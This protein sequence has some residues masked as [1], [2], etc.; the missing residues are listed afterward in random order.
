MN[1]VPLNHPAVVPARWRGRELLIVR[2]VWLVVAITVV[3]AYFLTLYLRWQQWTHPTATNLT[4]LTRLG[5]SP[6]GYAA[7]FAW[8]ELVSVTVFVITG[9]VLFKQRGAER[10]ALLTGLLLII[11]GISIHAYDMLPAGAG[12]DPAL[13]FLL[14]FFL[15]STHTGLA[16]F[17]YL[18]PNGHFAPRWARWLMALHSLFYLFWSFAPDALFI[19]PPWLF[20]AITAAFYLSC[21]GCQA[22]RYRRVSN[23]I[24]RQQAKWALS[25]VSAIVIMTILLQGIIPRLLPGYIPA[26]EDQ[27]TLAGFIYLLVLRALSP[28]TFTLLPITIA[29]SILHYRL[30]DI[31]LIINR[32]LVYGALTAF[33]VSTYVLSVVG[34][35]AVFQ[36]SGNFLCSLLA[37][38]IIAVA[39]QPLRTRIQRFINR[40][41]Y[42]ERDKPYTILS[43]FSRTLAAAL[44]PDSILPT[45]VE[46]V[47]QTLKLPYVA[48]T[49]NQEQGMEVV[50]AY[51]APPTHRDQ[52]R[53]LPIVYQHRQSGELLVAARSPY[54]RLTPTEC[55]LLNDI[56]TQ[57]GVTLYNRRLTRDLQRFREQLVTAREEERRRLLRD[58]HDGLGPRLAGQTLKLEA[59]LESLDGETETA[60]ALLLETM[61]E[62]Q[63]VIAEIRR[64]VYGLRPPV[65]DQLGL[66][67]AVREQAALYQ[68]QGLQVVVCI[69]EDLPPLPAAVEVAAYRIIQEAL[70]NVA[71]HAQA[72][73][74][75]VSIALEEDLHLEIC[76]DGI[77]LAPDARG[78][79][80]LASMQERAEEIGGRCLIGPGQRGG[81]RIAA[82]LPITTSAHS[83]R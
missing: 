35:G 27:P 67:M 17:C 13:H 63:N 50:A 40:L 32:T 23:A 65:L 41:M 33:V 26:G 36:T 48:I 81:L 69:P 44:L 61:A 2:V 66:L 3:L 47:A 29:C 30:W 1:S 19:A 58:L 9:F 54:E 16:L 22:Y 43:R 74:S 75:S 71:R 20:F 8:W 55:R 37:T 45:I 56:T 51:G 73:H 77:G 34:L 6:A 28:L 31:D 12:R 5:I 39:F 11:F 49:V 18:F 59:A 15:Y 78:G 38:G 7:Y 21:F 53:H 70:T 46:T 57:I 4:H 24:E 62:S 82:W 25:G 72:K 79:V 42:G 60:R 14:D 83:D 76:D 80:G 68:R 10:F 52:L 64:L